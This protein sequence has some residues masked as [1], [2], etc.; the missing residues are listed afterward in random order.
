VVG[1]NVYQT[2]LLGVLEEKAGSLTDVAQ[3][4]FPQSLAPSNTKGMALHTSSF[5]GIL[6]TL[7]VPTAE[8]A[9]WLLAVQVTIH[10]KSVLAVKLAVVYVAVVAPE[11][12]TT[13]AQVLAPA[14]LDCH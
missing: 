2:V 9:D 6:P 5:D 8:L 3:V 13:L 1:V 4:V 14:G 10:L 11:P 12:P 7:T